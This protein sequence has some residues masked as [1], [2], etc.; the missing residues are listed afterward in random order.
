[1]SNI[2]LEFK[3]AANTRVNVEEQSAT[4]PL[5]ALNPPHCSF[6]GLLITVITFSL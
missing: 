2:S 1:M 6:N 4:S 3:L 5:D